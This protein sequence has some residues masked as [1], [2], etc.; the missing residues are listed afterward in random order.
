MNS[1][2]QMTQDLLGTKIDTKKTVSLRAFEQWRREFIF[3]GLAGLRY[4]Q[5]FCNQFGIT[6]YI[7][8][9][10]RNIE[11]IDQ[12]IKTWYVRA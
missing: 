10:N 6:D 12:R 1:F 7:I 8:Y 4:G 3:E 5:A 11:E 9:Y 2:I